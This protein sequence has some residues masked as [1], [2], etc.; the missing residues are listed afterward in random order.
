MVRHDDPEGPAC[1]GRRGAVCRP[2]FGANMPYMFGLSALCVRSSVC[3][4]GHVCVC[5]LF[6]T[7]VACMSHNC[8][9]VGAYA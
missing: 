9:F 4:L 1:G 7:R 2:V 5:V 3:L 8:L 6:T